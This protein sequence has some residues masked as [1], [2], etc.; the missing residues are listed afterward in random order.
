ML[1]LSFEASASNL[2]ESQ[3]FLVSGVKVSEIDENAELARVKAVEKSQKIAFSS[4]LRGIYKIELEDEINIEEISNLVSSIEI[5]DETITDKTYSATVNIQ[6]NEEF[7]RFYIKNNY[8]HKISST[9][10][11][12]VIP[13][14]NENGFH[15]LWQKS[16]EWLRVWNSIPK[17]QLINIHVPIGDFADISNFKIKDLQLIDQETARILA[18]KYQVDKIIVAKFYQ[19][20]GPLSDTT[21]YSVILYELGNFANNTSI[22][23]EKH[24]N[25]TEKAEIMVSFAEKTLQTINAAWVNFANQETEN[26]R[27]QDFLVLLNSIDD[28][29]KIQNSLKKPKFIAD[30]KLKSISSKYAHISITFDIKILDAIAKLEEYNLEVLQGNEGMLILKNN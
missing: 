13:V 23:Q 15:K 3:Q 16:N 28:W 11:I 20:Y 10:E 25:Q 7:T 19:K 2:P 5:R 9:P 14:Y 24:P 17:E 21:D 4:L 22:V 1:L 30:Y 26:D 8:L 29:H 27:S 12:L 18:N 6:F